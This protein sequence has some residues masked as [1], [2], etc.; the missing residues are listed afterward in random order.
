MNK[1]IAFSLLGVLCSCLSP[2]EITVSA[3][4]DVEEL[5]Q[6]LKSL[7]IE[8]TGYQLK[9]KVRLDEEEEQLTL[10]FDTSLIKKDLKTLIES[11]FSRM[12]RSTNYSK[13]VSEKEL[14]YE[15]KSKE[16]KGPVIVRIAKGAGGIIFFEVKFEDENYLYQ[17]SQSFQLSFEQGL[18]NSY[19]VE[20]NRK[21]IG[22]DP[23]SYL[24]EVK[25]IK[26]SNL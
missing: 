4:A 26:E 8:Q 25:I 16:K 22:L 3:D 9:K 14:L 23:S 12:I 11:S 21:L 17:S 20:G 6:Q 13:E 19:K 18:L 1:V 15:R 2:D 24:I 10:E 7:T 5:D